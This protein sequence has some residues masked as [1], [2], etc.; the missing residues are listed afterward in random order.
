MK[1]SIIICMYNAE[2]FLER[3][4]KSLCKQNSCDFEIVMIDD[5]STDRTKKIANNYVNQKVKYYFKENGGISSARNLGLQKATGDF[6]TFVDVDDTVDIEYCRTICRLL[7]SYSPDV[8]FFGYRKVFSKN[9]REYSLKTN[10]RRL[11]RTEAVELVTA[12]EAVGNYL[13]NKVFSAKVIKNIRF[14]E[15]RKFEDLAV[16]LNLILASQ[17]YVYCDKCLYNY[18]QRED[19]I[20]HSLN[21]S[22][23]N[24]AFEFRYNQYLFLKDYDSRI[25]KK[26]EEN[27]LKNAIQFLLNCNE[28][29]Y[30][31]N[32]IKAKE[33]VNSISNANLFGIDKVKFIIVKYFT[34]LTKIAVCINNYRKE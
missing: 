8:L 7:S 13:W 4:L 23:I 14:P 1:L 28:T 6:I 12:N 19:S 24:D 32:F 10:E 21:A 9:K 3:C 2:C 16:T 15:G 31:E 20:M 18:I 26:T 27:M 33:L 22:S 5:G 17:T 11:T 34:L 29:N 30:T 25:A